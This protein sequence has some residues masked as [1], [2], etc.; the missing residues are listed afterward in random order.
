MSIGLFLF[1][2]CT[3]PEFREELIQRWKS[4]DTMFGKPQWFRP[5]AFGW[6]LRPVTWQG[7]VY[8]AVWAAT[9]ALPFVALLLWR[10]AAIEAVAWMAVSI[11]ALI[12]DV[13]QILRAMGESEKPTAEE[14]FYIGD[15]PA[16]EQLATRQFDMHLQNKAT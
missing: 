7:W 9:I 2:L 16:G 15:D 8:S 12:F 5:K 11:T 10:E 1:Y 4:E 13:R 3:D 6:G 14:V